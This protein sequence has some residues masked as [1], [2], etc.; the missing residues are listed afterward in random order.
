VQALIPREPVG[1]L[2]DLVAGATERAPLG[3]TDGKSGATLERVVI[4]GEP[5]VLKQLHVDHDWTMRG[6]GDLAARAVRLWTTGVLDAMPPVIDHAVVDAAIHLGRNGWGG[7]LLLRD[8][9]ADLIPEGDDP[10][11]LEQH[12]CLLD[13]MAEIAVRFWG[14]RDDLDLL[15]LSVRYSLFNPGW[16]D[17]EAGRG[18]PDPVPKIALDGW[19]R[20]AERCRPR[21][22]DAITELRHD[23]GPLVAALD[24]TPSTFLHGDWKMGNLGSHDDHRTILLDWTYPGSGPILHDL[25][26]YIALNRAR[27]PESKEGTIEA[28]RVSL[29]DRGIETAMWWERQLDLCL[30]G[31]LVQFGWEKALGDDDELDWWCDRAVHGIER[32]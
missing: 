16:L 12:R 24:E 26:W 28:L 29:E 17:A 22:R 20:F 19:D 8:V 1:S 31:G 23:I 3:G 7:A 15:P 4:D 32:L 2:E 11:S 21:L 6:F 25:T 18:W 13:H 30:L 9:S 14:W 27:L 5:F 10:I